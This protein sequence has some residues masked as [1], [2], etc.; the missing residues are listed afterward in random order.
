[1]GSRAR[2]HEGDA[3]DTAVEQLRKLSSNFHYTQV[4]CALITTA[5]NSLAYDLRTAKDKLD[6]ALADAEAEQSSVASDG[7]VSYPAAGDKVDGKV[8]EGG[9]VKGTASGKAAHDPID[10]AGEANDTADA[11]KR[12][13]SNHHDNPKYGRAVAIADRI[14]QAV[15]EATQADEKW[16][17]KLRRLKADDDMVVAAEDWADAKKDTGSVRHGAKDYLDEIPPPPENGDPKL[18][19]DWW[20]GLSEQERADYVSMHPASVGKLDG[21]PAEIRDEANRTLLAEKRAEFAT[22][23]QNTPGEPKPKFVRS[24]T[25]DGG[26]KYS[27]KWLEWHHKYEGKRAHLKA[28]LDGMDAIEKRFDRTGEDGL[29][30]AYLLGFD[31]ERERFALANGNPDTADHIAVYTPGTGASLGNSNG[32][33]NR[34]ANLWKTSQPMTDQKVSTITW[35]GYDAPPELPNAPRTNQVPTVTSLRSRILTEPR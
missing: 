16:A 6:A 2:R 8:P 4:E 31:P 30:K 24:G 12:Q 10:P 28:A 14:A 3:V 29:P 23:Y 7:S 21:L 5:L 15:H 22:Q 1:M 18:N 32:D 20:K 27:D 17:P 11:L 13:A 34:G 25:P 33:I 35:V 9:T 19:A 26:M